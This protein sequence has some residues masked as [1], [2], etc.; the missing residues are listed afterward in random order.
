MSII[1]IGVD[2]GKHNDPTA[3]AV[4]R[5][6]KRGD[7]Q[8][9]IIPFLERIDLGTPYPDI[10]RR[11]VR[12]INNLENRLVYEEAQRM[13]LRPYDERVVEQVRNSIWVIIDAT[14]VGQPVVD[15][16]R[17]AAPDICMCAVTFTY[18]EHNNV[19]WRSTEGTMGKAFLVSR[20]QVL[21]Q[22]GR[23]HLPDIPESHILIREL[24]DYEIRIT[25]TGADTYGAFKKGSHDDLVTALALATLLDHKEPPTI[26]QYNYI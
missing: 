17:E 20:L 7:D 19:L 23:V 25:D 9:F 18:G 16:L 14:G 6:E 13:L 3:I 4:A 8:H 21:M 22:A 26:K 5:M 12:L 2:V 11:L 10:S 15:F 1:T 24:K